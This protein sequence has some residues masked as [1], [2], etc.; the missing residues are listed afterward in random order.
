MNKGESFGDAGYI[1]VFLFFCF[2]FQFRCLNKYDHFVKINQ[3]IYNLCTLLYLCYT[4]IKNKFTDTKKKSNPALLRLISSIYSSLVLSSTC[5]LVISSQRLRILVKVFYTL[6][7][8]II[9]SDFNVHVGKALPHHS[10][11]SL[12]QTFI[13]TPLWLTIP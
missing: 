13:F 1:P 2:Y 10:L 5:L 3:A 4:S 12:T 11:T 8:A 9:L 7:P 6:N